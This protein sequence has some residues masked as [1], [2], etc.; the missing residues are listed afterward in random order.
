MSHFPN[1]GW[2]HHCPVQIVK[3]IRDKLELLAHRPFL[4][5]AAILSSGTAFAQA[6]SILTLPLITRLY[7]PED[8]S[9]LAV[10]MALIGI[11]AVVACL[12][13]NIAIPLP[14]KNEDAI[15]VFSLV[16]LAA[17]VISGLL[18]VLFMGAPEL[19][20]SIIGQPQFEPYLWMVPIGV[21]LISI[22]T[23]IQ[24]WFTR[25]KHFGDIARTK[26]AR[27]VSKSGTQIGCGVLNPTPFGLLLGDLV[28]CGVGIAGLF[29]KMWRYDRGLFGLVTLR[30][31]WSSLKEYRRFP[32][33]SVPESLLNVAA[34]QVPVLMIAALAV[35]PEAGHLFLAMQVTALPMALI[36]ASVAE[37]Y[38]SDAGQKKREGILKPFTM[39]VMWRLLKLGAP[40]L[41]AVG[42]ISPFVV[43]LIFGEDWTR[44]GMI[45]AWMTPWFILQFVASPVSMVLHVTNNQ[46]SAMV[47]QAFGL[48]LRV[49]TV[50]LAYLSFDAYMVE[51]FALS[52][53]AFYLVYIVTIIK[54]INAHSSPE[55]TINT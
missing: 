18:M 55:V 37:V 6:I 33:F 43:P 49:G 47:L 24:Y 4:R 11:F 19:I 52:G 5:N 15:N 7:S 45:I 35:Q 29:R 26:V 25:N 42:I 10:Y 12:R 14:E 41:L 46:F 9:L 44:A 1:S 51:L 48:I 20:L 8:F 54:I 3:I 38:L 23:S 53:A 16:I 13:L 32:Y 34:I 21:L 39:N 22:Y 36:G 30:S 31:L 2:L 28:Y 40:M 17:C 50:L 27:A